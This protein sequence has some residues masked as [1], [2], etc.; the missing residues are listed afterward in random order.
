MIELTTVER[1]GAHVGKT[2]CVRG[3]L[4][5]LSSKGKLHFAQLRDGTGI[6]Q[7]VLFK[8]NVPPE[9]FEKLGH[10][11]QESSLTLVG[12]VKSDERA[13]GGYEIDVTQGEIHQSV[14]GYPIT[15]KE[16]GIEYLLEHRHLWLRSKRTWAILRVRDAVIT[17]IRRFFDERGF[18]C[19]DSPIFTPNACEGTSTL[20]EVRRVTTENIRPVS[21]SCRNV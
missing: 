7:C 2:V 5:N 18:I 9:L 1:L 3:W 10:S 14:E 4:Y 11:G 15:P 21:V 12:M 13:P 19:V 20:F 16:H 8:N 6:V 17:A